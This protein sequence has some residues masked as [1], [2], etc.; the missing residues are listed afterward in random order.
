MRDRFGFAAIPPGV[1][2][3]P[4]WQCELRGVRGCGCGELCEPAARARKTLAFVGFG[5]ENEVCGSDRELMDGDASAWH[6]TVVKDD[7]WRGG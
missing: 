2:G 1:E 7:R 3:T 5:G 6:S 4:L